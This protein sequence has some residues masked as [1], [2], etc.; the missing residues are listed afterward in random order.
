MLLLGRGR[1]KIRSASEM[2]SFLDLSAEYKELKSEIDDAVARVLVSGH[3]VLGSEVAA[4]EEEFGHYC[5]AKHAVAVN[6][7]TSALHL[8]LL[9][10]GIGPGDEVLTTPFTF[11]ATVAAIGYTGAS[12]IYADID[13]A[14]FNLDVRGI[15]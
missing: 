1:A 5:Q 15:E 3:F 7:G 11:Y 12:A 4:F 10:A 13:P 8:A 2:I 14:T 9:A 6:S